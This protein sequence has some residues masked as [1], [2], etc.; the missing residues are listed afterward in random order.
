MRAVEADR[1]GVAIAVAGAGLEGDPVVR[2][3]LRRRRA[4]QDIA[5][6]PGR[7]L[8]HQPQRLARSSVARHD[9]AQR[10]G[11]AEP[12]QPG[13]ELRQILQ[14]D[15]DAAETH[16]KARR[17]VLRQHQIA[18]GLLQPRRQP[19]GADAVEQRDRRHVERQLQRLAHRHR[20]LKRHVEIFRRVV[21]EADR[22]VVDQAFR[23][24]KAVLESEAVDERFQRRAR[25]A[26]RAGHVDLPCAALVEIIGRADT[27]QHVA[28]VIV[29]R[30]DG[31]RNIR[32]QRQRAVA[33]QRLQH[34]L[35]AGVQ[36]Q[37][38]TGVSFTVAI[39]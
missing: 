8:I 30:D 12:R 33:R 26:H 13:I 6:L 25:R 20:A 15:A 31:D 34:L 17:F 2:G 35:Q 32:P 22:P 19:A 29:D 37:R 21:A 27:R 38:I 28:A 1:P 4:D 14:R 9:L 5:D 39:A 18:A 11:A 24:H 3:V 36:R 16:G 23:M 10:L 7:G